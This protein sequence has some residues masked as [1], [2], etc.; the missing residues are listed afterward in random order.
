MSNIIHV[1]NGDALD[2]NVVRDEFW[3]VRNDFFEKI[4][5]FN[6]NKSTK[7]KYLQLA[8]NQHLERFPHE[9]GLSQIENKILRVIHSFALM[10]KEIVCK[11]LIRQSEKTIYVFGNLQYFVYLKWLNKY[12]EIIESK[13]FL[14]NKGKTLINQ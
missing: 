5:G 1:L 3:V 9:N 13:Y 4:K 7:F 11:L 8:I 10:G 12:Y 14:N 6:F 2:L